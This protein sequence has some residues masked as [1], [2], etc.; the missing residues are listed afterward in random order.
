[1]FL[2][3]SCND[4][5][6]MHDLYNTNNQTPFLDIIKYEKLF[7]LILV[8]SLEYLDFL[9]AYEKK[10]NELYSNTVYDDVK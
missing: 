9:L 7:Y 3:V 2:L 8:I 4:L 10:E 5:K 6:W 1:M